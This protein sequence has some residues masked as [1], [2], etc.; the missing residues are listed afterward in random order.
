MARG[1]V[2]VTRRNLPIPLCHI[3]GRGVKMSAF[4]TVGLSAKASP[5]QVGGHIIVGWEGLISC[6]GLI[7]I[8]HPRPAGGC[9]LVHLPAQFYG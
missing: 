7:Y 9:L 1:E 2:K 4:R 5:R 8:S 3:G 6:G